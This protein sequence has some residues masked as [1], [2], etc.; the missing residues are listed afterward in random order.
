MS[1]HRDTGVTR[2]RAL[3]GAAAGLGLA[4]AGAAAWELFRRI[5]PHYR[6]TQ[7][8]DLLSL[9][10]DRDEAIVVGNVVRNK[11][12]QIEPWRIAPALRERLNG[13]TLEEVAMR[14]VAEARL[15]EAAGWLMPESVALLCA[16]AAE[17]E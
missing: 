4:A 16:L 10:P 17:M 9:L 8:D 2:R 11:A 13:H 5:R 15:V 6:Q 1:G 14:D 12:E 7:Y 3:A